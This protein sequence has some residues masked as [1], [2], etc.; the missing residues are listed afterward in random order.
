MSPITVRRG[1]PIREVLRDRRLNIY[2]FLLA[3]GIVS[4]LYVVVKLG[5]AMTVN[6]APGRT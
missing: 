4:L 2:D 1:L 6:Y 3:V 5:Q